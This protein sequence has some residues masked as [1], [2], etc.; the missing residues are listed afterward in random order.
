MLACIDSDMVTRIRNL[1]QR[2]DKLET[3]VPIQ[4]DLSAQQMGQL[5]AHEKMIS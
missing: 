5:R 3:R 4:E 1:E 2:I